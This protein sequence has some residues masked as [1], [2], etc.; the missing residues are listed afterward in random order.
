MKELFL[1]DIYIYPIKSLGGISLEQAKVQPTGLQYDR[2]WMLTDE[3]GNFLSQRTFAEMAILQV[4]ITPDGLSVCHKKGA[5]QPLTIPFAMH[6]GR[7]VSVTIWDDVCTAL[8]VSVEANT[9]FS[10]ALGMAARLMYMPDTTRRLVDNR[11]APYNEIV[12]FADAYPLL[13]IGESSLDDLNKRLE[14]PILMNRF[15]P[16]L[17]LS[18]GQPFAED[19]LKEF[20]IGEVAFAAVKPCARCVL[21]TLNQEAGVKGQEPLKTLATY[22]TYQNKVLFGQNLLQ[23]NIGTIKT[24]DNVEVLS[25][26]I[27]T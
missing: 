1:Q 26:S 25:A 23:R 17:V 19:S 7:E 27:K 22:R 3:K 4:S 5:L 9:W 21:I 11:Y 2:R 13:L 14:T 12:S 24:G 10:E 6:T 15:R 18:G 16:N 8:E 20:K